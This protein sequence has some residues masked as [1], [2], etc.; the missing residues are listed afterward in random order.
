M[1]QENVPLEG[2]IELPFTVEDVLGAVEGMRSSALPEN[3]VQERD[4]P[5][6]SSVGKC[7]RANAYYMAGEPHDEWLSRSWMA[8]TQEQGRIMEDLTF[9]AMEYLG[10]PVTGRQVAVPDDFP[11]TGHPDGDGKEWVTEGLNS[12]G[13][14]LG[15]EHKH[16]GRWEYETLFKQGLMQ[17]DPFI[18]VQGL[19]YAK[20]LG[21]DASVFFITSQDASSVHSDYTVNKHAKN[22]ANRWSDK[23]G[24]N[25]K[26][27]IITV[28]MRPLKLTLWPMI[29]QRARWLSKWKRE[30]GDPKN[31]A[32]D[33]DPLRPKK[34][35]EVVEEGAEPAFP[36]SYCPWY[37][38]CVVDGD[39]G[40]QAPV[41]PFRE[42]KE[43]D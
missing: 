19:V 21:W 11:L 25:P 10:F 41:L 30:D 7:G 29:E 32:R 38:K 15:V 40:V 43:Y 17:G 28:D 3:F 9:G 8:Y 6:A 14:V 34:K 36:C 22:P 24:W 2:G 37:N 5:R 33:Y 1:S 23:E 39:G 18:I 27:Q 13:L 42:G 20:A 26:L 12:E 4:K 35:G 31:V 16:F